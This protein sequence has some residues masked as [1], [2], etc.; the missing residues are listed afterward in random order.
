MESYITPKHQEACVAA[1]KQIVSYPSVCH[2]G[3]NGTPFG[4]AIQ[5][6]LEATLDLCQGLGYSVPFGRC[7]RRRSSV[8][9]NRAF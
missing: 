1:I 3:E 7:S 9:E 2:E 5:D 8:M 4:Q 6:V